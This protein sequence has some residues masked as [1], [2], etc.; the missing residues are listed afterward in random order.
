M[1]EKFG[2][3]GDALLVTIGETFYAQT[4]FVQAAILA[5]LMIGA[6]MLLVRLLRRLKRLVFGAPATIPTA[7]AP[8]VEPVAVA[9][10][11]QHDPKAT[12]GIYRATSPDT[13]Y[14][15]YALPA[16][17]NGLPN[18]GSWTSFA[19]TYIQAVVEQVGRGELKKITAPPALVNTDDGTTPELVFLVKIDTR[20]HIIPATT[21]IEAGSSLGGATVIGGK[22]LR[23]LAEALEEKLRNLRS[24]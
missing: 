21:D 5:V 17:L 24:S 23:E 19:L 12:F 15:M 4:Q 7:P 22:M 14:T 18:G 11:P 20:Y 3:D 13:T 16:G 9:P 8:A 6:V 1:L 2:K 10:Q